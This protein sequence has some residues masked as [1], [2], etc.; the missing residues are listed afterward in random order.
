M[1][2]KNQNAAINLPNAC[3]VEYEK[4]GHV[5]HF[6]E[7]DRRQPTAGNFLVQQCNVLFV[8]AA[9]EK[10]L[11]RER[12]RRVNNAG[13]IKVAVRAIVQRVRNKVAC[14]QASLHM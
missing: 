5:A 12:R 1:K 14:Q 6:E 10:G 11:K 7:F 3:R 2:I 9:A 13:S 4:R 8:R